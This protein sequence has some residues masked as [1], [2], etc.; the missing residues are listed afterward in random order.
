MKRFGQ[1][2]KSGQSLAEYGL[3]IALIAVVCITALGTLGNTL[4]QKLGCIAAAVG[5]GASAGA[6]G[7]GGC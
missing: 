5:A 6:G 3:C 4:S 7:G 1:Y 2:R